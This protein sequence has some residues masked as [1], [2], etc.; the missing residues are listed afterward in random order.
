MSFT[1][2]VWAQPA[3]RLPPSDVMQ[4]QA[5]LD[6]VCRSPGSAPERRFL[7]LAHALAARW[8]DTEDGPADV[9]D[10]GLALLETSP[11]NDRA[12]NVGLWAR[13]ARFGESF[14]HL[15]VQANDLGL[16]VLD[17]QNGVVYLANGEVLQLGPASAAALTARLDDAVLRKD[18]SS[19]WKEC[20]RLAP[21][22]LPEALTI[23]GLLTTQGRCDAPNPALGAALAQLS[24]TDP[25]KDRR[26]Q[27]CLD[28][29]PSARRIWQEQLL[30]YLRGASDLLAAVD[31]E[32][33]RASSTAS[34]PAGHAEGTVAVDPT[35]AASTKE[36]AQAAGIDPQ[37]VAS[38]IA[39]SSKAQFDLASRLLHV[40]GALALPRARLIVQWLEKSVAQG[41]HIAKAVM[42]DMLLRGVGGLPI[43]MERGLALLEEAAAAEDVD[44]LNYLA[45]FF[46][47][48][49]V[50]RLPD[51]TIKKLADPAS[52]SHQ[53][54]IPQLLMRAAA[55][56]SKRS[57]FWLAVR[58]WDEI[59]TPRD[60]VAAKAVMQLART[61]T[62]EL[63]A[64]QPETLKLLAPT[65]AD[66]DEVMALAR[67]LG[68]DMQ[69][70][71]ELLNARLSARAVAKP[72][73]LP[74]AAAPAPRTESRVATSR[75]ASEADEEVQP[76]PPRVRLHAGHVA[77]VL[78]AL[79]LAI[80][81]MLIPSMG[82]GGFKLLAVL[83]GVVS[84]FGVWRTTADWD[85]SG[86]KR[87][88]VS[89][90]ALVPGLGFVACVGVLLHAVRRG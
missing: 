60:D 15:I 76:S 33:E 17:G 29:V 48:K 53:T 75:R 85:W 46:Y 82:K 65:P 49:S 10:H 41:Q 1:L 79:G 58:L 72:P 84:A 2:T 52:Q 57:L 43:D 25:S 61:R 71:P 44:G 89:T 38:A 8:P 77:L 11:D 13:D 28:K 3:D 66:V 42:G 14:N 59:G 54:R 88:F 80:L 18:W 56:G 63:C 67:Q 50:R 31:A 4:A 16:H 74:V 7:T 62:P 81:L 45:D 34:V 35:L 51:G 64:E 12:Y 90:L 22:R 78:G 23:W 87:V 86:P 9:Y 73:A 30:A 70:L 68:A 32:A 55:V 6:E 27:Y 69:R 5:Q 47:N 37:L 19:A 40:P 24:G 21:Q 36:A 20:R 83:M 39:G 26:V